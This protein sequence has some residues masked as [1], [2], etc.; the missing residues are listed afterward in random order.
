MD[1]SCSICGN[2]CLKYILFDLVRFVRFLLEEHSFYNFLIQFFYNFERSD[3]LLSHFTTTLRP[4][5]M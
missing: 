5:F 4:L 2:S 1:N 3:P